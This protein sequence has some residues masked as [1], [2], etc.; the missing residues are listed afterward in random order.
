VTPAFIRTMSFLAVLFAAHGAC[1][2]LARR[3]A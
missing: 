3:E 2:A 1:L